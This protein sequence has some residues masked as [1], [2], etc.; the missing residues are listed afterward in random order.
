MYSLNI[1]QRCHV[2]T[3]DA[4]M[5]AE[6][7][8][9]CTFQWVETKYSPDGVVEIPHIVKLYRHVEDG[10]VV[11]VG[12]T[13]WLI[14]H[15][16]QPEGDIEYDTH[17]TPIFNELHFEGELRENQVEAFETLAKIRF[18]S[19][20]ADTGAGKTVLAAALTLEHAVKTLFIVP[21]K[22]L[23]N[24]TI[25]KYNKF[26]PGATTGRLGD[27]FV[28]LD[29]DVVVAIIN[30]VH[31]HLD[32]VYEAGFGLVFVDEAHHIAD[33]RYLE[34]LTRLKPHFRI[35]LTA[36]P[37]RY[38][39]FERYMEFFCG[40]ILADIKHD[41]PPTL[42]TGKI[43]TGIKLDG[44]DLS[45]E[46]KA[47]ETALYNMP[48]RYT[49]MIDMVARQVSFGHLCCV[50][51]GRVETAEI[52]VNLLKQ[53][54]LAAVQYTSGTATDDTIDDFV[55]RKYTVLVATNQMIT[56]GVDIPELVD[57]FNTVVFKDKKM[58][59]QLAGRLRRGSGY[60]WF[61]D[62]IDDMQYC[63]SAYYARSSHYMA[64]PNTIS[65][66]EIVE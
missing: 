40:Q 62:L 46:F 27:G 2:V 19:I 3:M 42:F 25:E 1:S 64:I 37:Y 51:V 34:V 55:N 52:V 33:N 39:G 9:Y 24:Q 20:R 50:V 54:G 7:E 5:I 6:I 41:D 45:R 18:G 15:Y 8:A 13:H 14:Q 61:F 47:W 31:N 44:Y 49:G 30:S 48:E 36:T 56:E 57:I 32:E 60:K 53:H 66:K 11:P 59:V 63:K 4:K 12:L 10:I 16:G 38:D 26:L 43:E 23:M 22:R 29:K 17:I 21:T 35:A 28:E 58:A 65:P